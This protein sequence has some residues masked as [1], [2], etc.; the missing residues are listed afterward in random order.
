LWLDSNQWEYAL[1]VPS[2]FAGAANAAAAATAELQTESI[3]K[4]VN[5]LAMIAFT[6]TASIRS[7][8]VSRDSLSP[9]MMPSGNLVAL[10]ESASAAPPCSQ[11]GPRALLLNPSILSSQRIHVLRAFLAQGASRPL[12]VASVAQLQEKS[13]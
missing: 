10:H 7:M 6:I 13:T 4:A 5:E 2:S 3:A 11:P 9:K 12:R 1:A 8:Q